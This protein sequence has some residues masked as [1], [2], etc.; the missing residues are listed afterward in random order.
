MS[1]PRRFL[2]RL[3]LAAALWAGPAWGETPKAPKV[4]SEEWEQTCQAAGTCWIP[5]GG[6]PQPI[7]KNKFDDLTF[8]QGVWSGTHFALP[9][10]KIG[11]NLLR[12][13][14][15]ME[16]LYGPWCLEYQTEWSYFQCLRII[17]LESRGNYNGA[18]KSSALI[19]RGLMSIDPKLGAKYGGDP[20]GDPEWSIAV[21][22]LDSHNRRKHI[23]E[24]KGWEWLNNHD[25]LE[26]EK[27]ASATGSLNGSAVIRWA[28]ESGATKTG[29]ASPFKR[30]I[31]WLQ[32]K[33]KIGKIWTVKYGIAVNPFRMGFRLGRAINNQD[34]FQLLTGIEGEAGMCFGSKKFYDPTFD[35]LDDNTGWSLPEPKKPYTTSNVWG[36][37]CEKHKAT[38]A[39]MLKTLVVGSPEWKELQAKGVFPSDS[40]YAWFE[41]S[42]GACRVRDLPLVKAAMEKKP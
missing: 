32:G 2:G 5:A 26:Q 25:R 6:K 12:G 34:V 3:L 33:D 9:G 39:A 14:A 21:V 36:D 27:W 41:D 10:S 17:L 38:T 1:I 42:I 35:V 19:E 18:T 23:S 7:V 16:E 20:C 40:E 4:G 22:S 31:G 13:M 11:D 15:R 24:A 8:S 30:M 28:E 29:V 37:S